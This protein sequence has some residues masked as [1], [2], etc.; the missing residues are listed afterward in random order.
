[1]EENFLRDRNEWITA[2]E[3]LPQDTTPRIANVVAQIL[4]WLDQR[5]T[6][7]AVADFPNSAAFR[8]ELSVTE[9]PFLDSGRK[10]WAE[11]M[12]MCGRIHS[13]AHVCM[14]WYPAVDIPLPEKTERDSLVL[15]QAYTDAMCAIAAALREAGLEVGFVQTEL[16]GKPAPWPEGSD[17][18]QKAAPAD[19]VPVEATGMR[20]FCCNDWSKIAAALDNT[21]TFPKVLAVRLRR[22]AWAGNEEE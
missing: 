6:T 13:T 12:V 9:M 14:L 2:I 11:W 20:V 17:E 4:D 1:M 16:V 7:R 21:T 5:K 8:D 3:R 10:D 19:F 18:A 22:V 15:M